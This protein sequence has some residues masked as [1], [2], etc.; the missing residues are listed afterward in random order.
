[1]MDAAYRD[2][3]VVSD[4]TVD[5]HVKNLR[6]KLAGMGFDPISSVYRVGYRFEWDADSD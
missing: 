6:H 3:R 4:C 1:M 2:H 5:S